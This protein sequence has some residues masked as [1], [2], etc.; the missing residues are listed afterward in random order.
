MAPGITGILDISKSNLELMSVTDSIKV[1]GRRVALTSVISWRQMQS[2]ERPKSEKL[3]I[4]GI[5]KSFPEMTSRHITE[6]SGIER[7][8]VIRAIRYLQDEGVIRVSRVGAC[9]TT[10]KQVRFY[11]L[12]IVEPKPQ[13][14]FD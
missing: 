14:L 5:L 8:S 13:T 12:A 11:A 6:L 7:T 9:P 4:V 1:N 2:T 3:V 10:G